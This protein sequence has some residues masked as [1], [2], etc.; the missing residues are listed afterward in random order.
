MTATVTRITAH[1]APEQTVINPLSDS[2]ARRPICPETSS[3]ND[4][5]RGSIDRG[6]QVLDSY[7]RFCRA[8]S[9]SEATIRLRL[10]W[11]KRA[12]R[13]L[14][15]ATITANELIDWLADHDWKPETR[16][17]ARSAL[18]SFFSWAEESGVRSD[19]PAARL[20][21][22]RVPTAM[23][24]PCPTDVLHAALSRANDR[25]RMMIALAAFAGLRCAEIACLRWVDVSGQ[26]LRVHGKGGKIRFVPISPALADM[27]DQHA[28]RS[29]SPFVVPSRDGEASPTN[30]SRR[31]KSA[32]GGHWTGHTLR[33]RFATMAY[34]AQRDLLTVQRLLG[35]SNPETTARYAEPPAEAALAAVLGAAA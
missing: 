18:R 4:V 7:V 34:R 31:L 15:L 26:R 21:T 30:V 22:V 19:N 8:Q 1:G 32:L 24:R 29:A 17:A 2:F 16:R 10:V 14:G 12:D 27:L 28:A 9:Q 6:P 20:R 3:T 5:T 33:H 23:P 35:H 11:L 13:E 25:D